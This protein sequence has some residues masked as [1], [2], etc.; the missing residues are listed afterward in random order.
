[1]ALTGCATTI[2][3]PYG[4]F[5]SYTFLS[6]EEADLIRSEGVFIGAPLTWYYISK[7]DAV[8]AR[9]PSYIAVKVSSFHIPSAPE[10]ERRLQDAVTKT[11]AQAGLKGNVSTAGKLATIR[12]QVEIAIVNQ[13][14][15]TLLKQS[16]GGLTR[17]K[18]GLRE[19]KDDLDVQNWLNNIW[20]GENLEWLI[21]EG[22]V[23][24]QG[25]RSLA[26][27]Q[28]KAVRFLKSGLLRGAVDRKLKR[29]TEEMV[30]SRVSQIVTRLLEACQG[31]NAV[32]RSGA[33]RARILPGEGLEAKPCSH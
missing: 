26:A 1:L 2:H 10:C 22:R 4:P 7:Q 31:E 11:L 23:V 19:R 13:R 33:G 6:Q 24:S 29:T 12:W 14:T 30:A 20:L 18:L 32:P 28:I 8:A 21:V 25:R 16:L 15:L 17:Y 9:T 3:K 27:F 5:V